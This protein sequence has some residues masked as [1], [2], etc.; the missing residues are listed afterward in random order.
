MLTFGHGSACTSGAA[1]RVC[2]WDKYLSEAH[3]AELGGRLRRHENT[4]CPLGGRPF[5]E[6][7]SKLLARN[8]IP[9]KGG[10]PKK[11]KNWYGVPG[12]PWGPI[13]T[14]VPTTSFT[15]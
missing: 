7:F 15:Q 3:A 1:G 6:R 11:G 8:L 2:T 9:G 13:W 4:G 12:L 5:L 10:R 14:I